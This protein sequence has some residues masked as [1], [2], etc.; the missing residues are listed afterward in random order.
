MFKDDKRI[1]MFCG[2]YGSGKTEFAVNY[3]TKLK[4]EVGQGKKVVISDMD[5]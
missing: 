1:R 2:H 3:V 4:E 5:M